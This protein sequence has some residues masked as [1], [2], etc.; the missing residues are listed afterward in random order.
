MQRETFALKKKVV[1]YIRQRRR[2]CAQGNVDYS[3]AISFLLCTEK[4][5]GWL[6]HGMFIELSSI[7]LKR[8]DMKIV[9]IN[10][11]ILKNDKIENQSKELEAIR[12]LK[13]VLKF[14]TH[15]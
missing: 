9:E 7:L 3:Q 2:R 8:L 1:F 11:V 12:I 14:L 6:S 5:I 13:K 15:F 4:Y 10:F